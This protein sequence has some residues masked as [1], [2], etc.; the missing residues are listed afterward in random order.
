MDKDGCGSSGVLNI[1]SDISLDKCG[2]FSLLLGLTSSGIMCC[3]ILF[4]C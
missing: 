1:H 3:G 4:L 2:S